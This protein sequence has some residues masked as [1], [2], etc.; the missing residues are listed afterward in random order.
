MLIINIKNKHWYVFVFA[1]AHELGEARDLV[2]S[3]SKPGSASL[4][5]LTAVAP[6][7]RALGPKA[8]PSNLKRLPIAAAAVWALYAGEDEGMPRRICR[9]RSLVQLRIM[10]CTGAYGGEVR[11]MASRCRKESCLDRE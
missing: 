2:E 4:G 7:I 10:A 3:P 9:W 6:L 8:D 1:R 5:V 11:N